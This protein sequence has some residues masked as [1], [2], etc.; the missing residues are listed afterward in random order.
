[1]SCLFHYNPSTSLI[2]QVLNDCARCSVSPKK[3]EDYSN[4][5][6]W[7]CSVLSLC[8]NWKSPAVTLLCIK[9]GQF[10]WLQFGT[11]L[12]EEQAASQQQNAARYVF[13]N[14]FQEKDGALTCWSP[15][16]QFICFTYGLSLRCNGL[17]NL[18]E[19]LVGWFTD[20]FT[21]LKTKAKNFEWIPKITL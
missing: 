11:A 5:C 7:I 8:W 19:G 13:I 20:V 16:S 21:R 3:R 17:R 12:S 2:A 9:H 4:L 1:M 14:D 6:K 10:K 18:A 15:Q